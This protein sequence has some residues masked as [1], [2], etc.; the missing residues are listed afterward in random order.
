MNKS[1]PNRGKDKN[2]HIQVFV[3]VRPFNPSESNGKSHNII[4][5]TPPKDLHVREKI[6]DRT[7]KKFTFDKVFGPESNQLMVYNSVVSPLISEVLA[8]YNCTVFAYGQ[9]GTGKTFTMEGSSKDP[10]V[11]WQANTPAGIIPRSLSHLFDQLRLQGSLEHTIKV[12]FLELYNEELFDLLDTGDDT[13]KLRLYDDTSKKGSVIIQG[14][15]EVIVHNKEQVYKILERG[16]ERR[17][18]A[19]TLMNA[20]S[21]R[22]HTVFS[23]T[24]HMK[25][26]T[27]EGEELIKIGKLNLVDL[28][29]SENVGRS[30][31][32]DRR[33]REAGSINQSL[34]TLGRVITALV[35]RAPHVPYRESKLTRLLQ[36]SLGGRTKTSIIA[37]ISPSSLNLEETLSTLDYAHRAKNITNRPEINQ[38]LMKATLIKEYTEEIERLKRDVVAARE[39]NGVYLAPEDYAHQQATIA[40]QEKEI[41]EK[42]NHIKALEETLAAKEKLF[43]ELNMNYTNTKEKA[44][45]LQKEKEIQEFLVKNYEDVKEKLTQQAEILMNVAETVTNDTEKLHEKIARIDRVEYENLSKAHSFSQQVNEDFDNVKTHLDNTVQQSENFLKENKDFLSDRI[46]MNSEAVDHAINMISK[47]TINNMNKLISNFLQDIKKTH[48]N[49][50]NWI[51]CQEKNVAAFAD[52]QTQFFENTTEDFAVKTEENLNNNAE[53]NLAH[54]EMEMKENLGSIVQTLIQQVANVYETKTAEYTSIIA[55]MENTIAAH[56]K[57]IQDQE[58][59]QRNQEMLQKLD[60]EWWNQRKKIIEKGAM[61][62]HNAIK[63]SHETIEI[64]ENVKTSV[65]NI[66]DEDNKLR[67]Y[68]ERDVQEN[69]KCL[70]RNV[71]KM[72]TENRETITQGTIRSR[73]IAQSLKEILKT[74]CEEINS[75]RNSVDFSIK[76]RKQESQSEYDESLKHVKKIENCI[77]SSQKRHQSF[78]ESFKNDIISSTLNQSDKM[79]QQNHQMVEDV[80]RI[81]TTLGSMNEKIEKFLTD[82]LK[83]DEPTGM[84]PIKR[85]YNFPRSLVT[86]SP[87]ERLIQKYQMM[88]IYENSESSDENRDSTDTDHIRNNNFIIPESRISTNT[89]DDN[90]DSDNSCNNKENSKIIKPK[91]YAS[92]ESSRDKNILKAYNN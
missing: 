66:T 13:P 87:K 18:T 61:F 63:L 21:S 83:K 33:A 6:T 10:A 84:T 52:K 51:D 27:L 1:Q 28:A 78:L 26:V 25:E 48:K 43:D 86:M 35:E 44:N 88:K 20:H 89:S 7:T 31:A 82:E 75:Y 3:R 58:E 36:E 53:E 60:E 67:E 30:G 81:K 77:E 68:I 46:E 19:A 41:E 11:H 47:E 37:T 38:K 80:H 17:Q 55:Q 72:I 34:L 74:N 92:M 79:I 14:L 32:I 62:T 15:E 40:F 56:N 65:R 57:N 2:Q 23:V 70:E 24:V 73:E 16:S 49:N 5:V 22:S 71:E 12:S 64:S 45:L 50:E 42:L 90:W 59:L 69:V 91:K 54:I 8:G 39:R 9:T 85:E 29:G 4:E 76:D